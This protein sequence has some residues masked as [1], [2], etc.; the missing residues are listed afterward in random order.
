MTNLQFRVLAAHPEPHAAAP[1]LVFRILIQSHAPVHAI[2]LNCQ[3]QIE[4]RRRPHRP[5]EQ[6]CLQDLFGEASR[7]KDTLRPLLWT[8]AS[9]TVPAFAESIEIDLPVACT[10]DFDVSAAKYLEALEDGEAPLLFLFSG[11]VFAKT[12][13]GFQV[14]QVPWDKEASYR[15]PLEVWR[16]LMDSFFPGCVWIRLGHESLNLLQRFRARNGLLSWDDT[17]QALVGARE[18]AAQ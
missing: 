14:E 17:I 4:P 13:N 16:G 9:L 10:Y 1:T 7:W 15:M 12:A 6:E 3:L 2:L 11:T 18:A 8:R 5:S